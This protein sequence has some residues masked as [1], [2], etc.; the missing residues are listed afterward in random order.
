MLKAIDKKN[1]IFFTFEEFLFGGFTII[2]QDAKTNLKLEDIS[3]WEQ[4]RICTLYK[5]GISARYIMNDHKISLNLFCK[6][7]N[8]N[9]IKTEKQIAAELQKKEAEEKIKKDKIKEQ[10]RMIGLIKRQETIRRK[11]IEQ[12]KKLRA[13]TK[14]EYK[15]QEH[16]KR[17]EKYIKPQLEKYDKAFKKY[18]AMAKKRLD[19][20]LEKEDELELEG[21]IKAS[22]KFYLGYQNPNNG[23]HSKIND[24]FCCMG[25]ES[26]VE[27]LRWQQGEIDKIK[28]TL[29]RMLNIVS[30]SHISKLLKN[31]HKYKNKDEIQKKIY[32]CEKLLSL[33]D[34][35]IKMSCGTL[36]WHDLKRIFYRLYEVGVDGIK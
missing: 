12:Y 7:L 32:Y 16:K 3:E 1:G 21:E 29:L 17:Y 18:K 28:P 14:E 25:Y 30:E 23:Y 33:K 15:K 8:Q 22:V 35:I 6:V 2:E 31:R 5:Q 34:I 11:K 19:E 36:A 10:N 24:D 9:G 4:L 26:W 13:T 27:Y 20:C